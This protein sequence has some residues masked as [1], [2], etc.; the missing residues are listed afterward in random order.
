MANMDALSLFLYRYNNSSKRQTIKM[1]YE[2]EI[3]VSRL[4]KP[5]M[6]E[7]LT[8]TGRSIDSRFWNILR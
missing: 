3:I 1:K 8:N 5:E 2:Q 6:I 7:Y 4:M